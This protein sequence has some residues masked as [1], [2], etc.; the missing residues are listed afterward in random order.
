MEVKNNDLRI[1]NWYSALGNYEKVN[2]IVLQHIHESIESFIW[3]QPIP[4]TEDWLLKFGFV[5]NPYEDRYEKGTIHI[6]C[7]KTKGATYLWI[8]NM[9]HIKYVH[10]LQNLY[11]ALTG[12]ELTDTLNEKVK[13][14]LLTKVA[15]KLTDNQKSIPHD[16]NQIIT[17]NFNDLI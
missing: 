6:E 12:E 16:F 4:L 14:E 15:S 5:S 3:V 1:G 10:Q 7:D 2:W 8:E 9:P 17:E 13:G 11:F